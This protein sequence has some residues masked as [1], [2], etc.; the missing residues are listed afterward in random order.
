MALTLLEHSSSGYVGRTFANA[1]SADLTL[2]FACDF[3]TAGEKLTARS[4]A[5]RLVRLRLSGGGDPAESAVCVL[6][7]KGV[8]PLQSVNIAG[9]GLYT[10]V[11][12]SWT[13]A[14]INQWV[15]DVLK[16]VHHTADLRT[17]RS[18]GQ[19]GVDLAGL[20]AGCALGL[21]T[22]GLFP[23]G[24]RQRDAEGIDISRSAEDLH[25]EINGWVRALRR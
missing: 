12:Y 10:L 14:R 20:V 16:L 19:T 8:R 9:N 5:S 2:A 13:Q 6:R 22:T 3:T 23:R 4:A 11:Q 21:P 15:Y 24:F 18:G 25:A 17:V 7:A 1:T